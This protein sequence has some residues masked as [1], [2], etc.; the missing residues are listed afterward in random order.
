VCCDATSSPYSA[1]FLPWL[2][3][4][5]SS[6]TPLKLGRFAEPPTRYVRPRVPGMC[7]ASLR[8]GSDQCCGKDRGVSSLAP[9]A[10]A[11]HRP[12][13]GG[14]A[15]TPFGP[16]R[17]AARPPQ[18]PDCHVRAHC[19]A[20]LRSGSDQCCGKDRA[21]SSRHVAFFAP[22]QFLPTANISLL[23]CEMS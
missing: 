19:G 20:L 10:P 17:D 2:S 1:K 13:P 12:R 6:A 7:G 16:I 15:G 21:V 22:W 5:S 3:S 11:Y 18:A 9:C 23:N 8:S 14:G 4:L